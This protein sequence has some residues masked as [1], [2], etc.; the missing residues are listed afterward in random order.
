MEEIKINGDVAF[1]EDG[2]KY[3]NLKKPQL[4]YTSVTTLI[5][6][7][8]EA[9]NVDFW[10]GYKALEK[11]M[12]DDFK[13]LGV[14]SYL[15]ERKKNDLTISDYV[16]EEE[17]YKTKRFITES[18]EKKR[19]ES[20]KRGTDIHKQKELR[21]YE[22]NNIN[23]KN[24]GFILHDDYFECERNNFDLNRTKA[25]LPEYLI[26]YSSEDEILNLAGQIDLLIKDGND[27][28]IY[29]FK[30]NADGI[31]SKAYFDHKKKTT[32]KMFY[33]INNLEDTKLMHYTLQLSLY[34]WMLQQINPN[35]NI[36]K[37][38]LIHIDKEGVETQIEVEYKKMEIERLL[39]VFKKELK[40]TNLKSDV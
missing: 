18:Y 32:K 2:H 7:F 36:K 27:I 31:E 21:F 10:S 20:A 39:K 5:S 12:G 19:V 4:K 13:N 17:Y 14:K 34:A 30:T 6:S 24:L 8:H 9:F 33:P 3:V 11:L 40:I 25:V 1:Y 35:L 29:D 28:F 38:T 23:P 22:S 16:N 15:L 37:L 26:Y